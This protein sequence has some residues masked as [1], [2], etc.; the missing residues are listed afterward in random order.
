[1]PDVRDQLGSLGF[2]P[3]GSTPAQFAD[4]IR[5]EIDRWAKV[6]RAAGISAQ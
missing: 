1:M 3:I 2:E 4:R 5:F 6:I